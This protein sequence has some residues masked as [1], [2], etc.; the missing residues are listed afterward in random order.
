[1]KFDPLAQR[2]SM[3]PQKNLPTA[4]SVDEEEEKE[5]KVDTPSSEIR[6]PKKN[7]AIAAIDRLLFYSP[8][9]PSATESAVAEAKQKKVI[10]FL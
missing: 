8:C 3:L 9:P 1:M 2:L 7:P 10:F 4:P 6:T 5:T